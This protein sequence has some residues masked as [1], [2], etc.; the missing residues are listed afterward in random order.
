[1]AVIAARPTTYRGI[2]MRSRL[3]AG[4]AQWL[5]QLGCTW[6]YE[7][8]CF[9]DE[10]GQY[11]PDFL[12][13]DVQLLAPVLRYDLYVEVKPTADVHDAIALLDGPMSR[14]F[15]SHP[16]PE[17][18]QPAFDGYGGVLTA[19]V[20]EALGGRRGPGAA[21]LFVARLRGGRI[22]L[23][24]PARIGLR[25]TLALVDSEPWPDLVPWFGEWWKGASS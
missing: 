11:L 22:D 7:P 2:R 12:V 16:F 19:V 14:I 24:T 9:A 5:D 25:G 18:P 1:M 21:Q 8:E 17:T 15:A 6:E 4:F 10:T 20:S 23:L 13:R 3:E